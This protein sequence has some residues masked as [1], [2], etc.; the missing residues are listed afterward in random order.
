MPYYCHEYNFVPITIEM[1]DIK[2]E[3]HPNEQLYIICILKEISYFLK[4]W[5]AISN[6]QY[7]VSIFPASYRKTSTQKIDCMVADKKQ[8]LKIL[9]GDFKYILKYHLFMTGCYF[10]ADLFF[11][12]FIFFCCSYSTISSPF[13]SKLIGSFS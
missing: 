4:F 6:I 13:S 1:K 2:H 12:N 7:Y 5:H 10:I 9:P 8:N 3:K 11:S